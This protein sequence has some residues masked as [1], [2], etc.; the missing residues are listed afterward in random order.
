MFRPLLMAVCFSFAWNGWGSYAMDEQRQPDPA[1]AKFFLNRV[2]AWLRGHVFDYQA[3]LSKADQEFVTSYLNDPRSLGEKRAGG[4]VRTYS[5]GF[6]VRAGK[7]TYG[8]FRFVRPSPTKQDQDAFQQVLQAHG[9]K[10]AGDVIGIG[11]TASP[12][13]LEV[14]TRA[15]RLPADLQA[16]GKS[17]K[18]GKEFLVITLYRNGKSVSVSAVE[19]GARAMSP[20]PAAPFASQV[21]HVLETQSAFFAFHPSTFEDEALSIEGRRI[22]HQIEIGL[23]L[24]PGV[25]DYRTQLDYGLAYP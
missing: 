17:G 13:E 20:C 3:H 5:Y 15:S 23:Q 1:F 19:P 8:P 9:L 2:D 16:F 25:I 11:F 22:V 7:V 14:I 18:S 24:S 10:S 21:D 6:S 12:Q 4:F